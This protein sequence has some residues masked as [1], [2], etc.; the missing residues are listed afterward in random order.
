MPLIVFENNSNGV[1]ASDIDD[2]TTTITL[3]GGQGNNFPSITAPDE[4]FFITLQN[5]AAQLIEICRVT[6]RAGDVLTVLRGQD[7][8][9]AKSWTAATTVVQLRVTKETLEQFVQQ[10]AALTPDSLVTVNSLGQLTSLTDG[11]PRTWEFFTS[12]EGQTAFNTSATLPDT[13]NRVQAFINGVRQFPPDHFTVTGAQ[14]LTF[15]EG[16]AEGDYVAIGT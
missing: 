12:T 14:Q 13:D 11:L 6:N 8:T 1:L 3:V 9:S 5:Y 4:I 15:T 7:G 16:L 2:V 10:A